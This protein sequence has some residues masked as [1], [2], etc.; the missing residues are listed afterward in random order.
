MGNGSAAEETRKARCCA[1]DP[2]TVS[3]RHRREGAQETGARNAFEMQ[4]RWLWAE[5]YSALCTLLVRTLLVVA[6]LAWE[7]A[8]NRGQ[9]R[10]AHLATARA[11]GGLE[12]AHSCDGSL[13]E[14]YVRGHHAYNSGELTVARKL[15]AVAAAN[16]HAGAQTFM[17]F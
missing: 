16:G 3:K 5:M 13:E 9:R 8:I 6:N 1:S 2:R 17:V 10:V 12:T 7:A 11:H 4:W 14:L 15:Y